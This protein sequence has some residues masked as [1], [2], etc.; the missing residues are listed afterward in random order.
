MKAHFSSVAIRW[1]LIGGIALSA[2]WFVS[3]SK[4]P[5]RNDNA[6]KP[7]FRIGEVLNY[8][9]DWQHYTGA[10]SA[11]LQIVDR[12]DFQGVPVW[13]FRATL[14]TVEPIRALY[15]MDDQID[16][17]A[18]PGSFASRQYHEHLSEFGILEN[19][20]AVLAPPGSG[21][22]SAEP[23]VIVPSGTRDALSAIYFL[24]A[25]DWTG[26]QE[27]RAPVYDGQNVYQLLAKASP[28]SVIHVAAGTYQGTEIE[29]Q[30]F[31]GG[32]QVPDENFSL[33]ISDDAA[34]TP[35]LCKANLSIGSV[36]IE[37]ISDS[38]FETNARPGERGATPPASS[39][40]RAGS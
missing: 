2:P 10:G 24:R 16:S 33:W 37:L 6:R 27:I 1:A 29:I 39:N 31:D 13:H 26:V 11:Q 7:E 21:V 12:T 8:R 17:Y 32:K 25:V 3:H 38:S 40:H 22:V 18:M 23:R 4:S 19:T 34:R 5:A 35:L 30:L 36:R 20:E 9:I 14:H 15:P 28:P